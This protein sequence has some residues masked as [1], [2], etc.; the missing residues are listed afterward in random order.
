MKKVA[1]IIFVANAKAFQVQQSR[2]QQI[3][4]LKMGLFDFN[5]VHGSGSGASESELNDQY[6]MQQEIVSRT[7]FIPSTAKVSLV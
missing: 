2:F 1:A 6:K 5:P 3:A 4:P 7:G